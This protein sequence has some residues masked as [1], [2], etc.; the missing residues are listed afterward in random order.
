VI[1]SNNAWVS[2]MAGDLNAD[3]SLRVWVMTA[4]YSATGDLRHFVR[5]RRRHGPAS[6]PTWITRISGS[7]VPFSAAPD[8]T[9]HLNPPALSIEKTYT[10][11]WFESN[12]DAINSAVSNGS[13]NGTWSITGAPWS[14]IYFGQEKY[15]RITWSLE[16]NAC[17]SVFTAAARWYARFGA[18]LGLEYSGG[19]CG[20][21]WTA[22]R[23][24]TGAAQPPRRHRA[25]LMEIRGHA[26]DV[27]CLAK[28]SHGLC[29][30]PA[31]VRID[32][33][34]VDNAAKHPRLP[35]AWSYL[36]SLNA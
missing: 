26:I 36:R 10:S 6:D 5:R 24:T 21:L 14:E 11:E 25:H 18:D 17:S 30:S 22:R 13:A 9:A 20:A 7:F 2:S 23:R 19:G 33:A 28:H 1:T 16:L 3:G 32:N 4:T 34:L 27:H 35:T 31:L 12:L 15:Y 8:L 29:L